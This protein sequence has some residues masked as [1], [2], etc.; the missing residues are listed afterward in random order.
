MSDNVMSFDLWRAHREAENR[1]EDIEQCKKLFNLV[2]DNIKK[3]H[4]TSSEDALK[5]LTT[6]LGDA[7]PQEAK[8]EAPNVVA[9]A[10]TEAQEAHNARE[11]ARKAKAEAREKAL[12]EF[13]KILANT[14]GLSA[15][16]RSGQY[17]SWTIDIAQEEGRTA[18]FELLE[19]LSVLQEAGLCAAFYNPEMLS[20]SQAKVKVKD[21]KVTVS[22][23]N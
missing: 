2:G 7:S 23:L 22:E 1:V 18:A 15:A 17:T 3:G 5:E 6:L 16:T 13:R 12:G 14:S 10:W 19:A 8:D 9:R 11:A 20:P 4:Y 21:M